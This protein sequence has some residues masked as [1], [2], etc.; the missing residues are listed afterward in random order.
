MKRT[1][2]SVVALFLCLA[3]LVLPVLTSCDRGGDSGGTN[4]ENTPE[5]S[6][7]VGNGGGSNSVPDSGSSTPDNGNSNPDT[8]PTTPENGNSGGSESSPVLATGVTLN[9]TTLSL[10]KGS[11]ETLTA[12]VAPDDTTDT[13]L[14]WSTSNENVATVNNNG[15]VTAVGAGTATITVTTANGKTATC[16]VTVSV[17]ASGVSLNKNNLSLIKGSSETL[18]ATVAPADTTDKTVNWTSSN[19]SVVTVANGT[20]TAVAAGMATITVTTANGK[21]ATCEVT[22]SVLA[23]GVSLNKN[24]LSLIKGSSETLT[25]T[26]APADTTDKTLTWTSSNTSVVTVVNGT[27][28]AVGAGTTTITVTTANG[29]TATCDVTV[30]VLASGVSLNKNTL[31]LIKGNSETLTA[32]VA[33]ADAINKNVSWTT[34]NQN[35]VTV[36]NGTVT[37]VGAGTATITVTDA[38]G[39]TDTCEV[40]VTVLALGITLD[41]SSI[42]LN[43]GETNTLVATIAPADTTDKSL[44]WESSNTI[45]A[46]VID[47][48]VTAVSAGTT[49]ITVTTANGKAATCQVTVIAN[50]I[51]FKTL[52]VTGTDIYGKVSN[53]TTTFSF[54]NEVGVSGNATFEVYRDLECSDIIRSK[55]TTL[56]IGDNTFYILEYISGEVNALYTVTVRRK[57]MYTV[58]F[59]TKGGMAVSNQSI[60]EDSFVTVPTTTR[61]GYTFV[62][63]DRDLALPITDNTSISAQWSNNPYTVTYNANGGE[64]TNSSTNVAYGLSYTLETPTRAGYTFA[65]WYY[66]ATPIS[67]TGTW[68][69]SES[70]MLKAEWTANTNTS[71]RVKHY[72]EKLDGSY[73]LKDT[74]NLTGT[75]DAEVTPNTKTYAGFTEPTTQTVTVLP[76]GTQA[77][78][79]YYTRNSYTI[80]FLNEDGTEIETK[81]LKYE[82]EY[83]FSE[84][85]KTG[86]AFGWY[87]GDEKFTQL[88]G[89][90]TITESK[91]LKATWTA[92]SNTAYKVEHYIEK[93]DGSY[94]LKDTD[95]LTGTS[96]T[97]IK[98]ET[99][100]Y[101]GFTAPVTQTVTVLPDGSQV[102]E[103]Y[104]TRNNYAVSFDSNG[105]NIVQPV[106][107]KYGE[108][109]RLPEPTRTGYTFIGW[110]DGDDAFEANGTWSIVENVA[111]KAEWTAN[112]DTTYKVEHYIEKLDGMYEIKDTDNLTG[113][114]DS[115]VTPVIKNY[116]GF[117]APVTQTVTVLP[118][119][120]QV[121]KY[122]YT[123]NSYT[124]SFDSNGG[125]TVQSVTI[126]Y[127][128]SYS[129]TESERTGYTFVGWYDGDDAFELNGTWSIVENVTLKAEWSLNS[130]SLT[131]TNE[132]SAYGSVT[133][134]GT[135][136]YNSSVTVTA[137][138]V[139][140]NTFLGW[141]DSNGNMLSSNECFTFIKKFDE[142]IEARWKFTVDMADFTFTFDETSCVITGVHDQTKTEY[143]I[144]DYVTGI[145]DFAFCDCKNI[146]SIA[147]PDSITNIG[148][149]SFR[150]CDGLNGVYIDSLESW[151]SI[152]F[153]HAEYNPLF[154]AGNLY[155]NGSLVTTLLIPDG[156]TYINT[157][158]FAY[159]DSIESVVISDTVKNISTY[160]FLNCMN[161][162][163]V[164]VGSAVEN[165][166]NSA[167][168]G[169]GRLVEIIN[170][171]NL[172]IV[173]GNL[174]EYGSIA[175]YAKEVH[176]GSSKI[177]SVDEFLFY[178][179]S[180]TTYLLGYHGEN[181][182]LILP[183]NYNGRNYILND[184]VFYRCE[185]FTNIAISNGVI[186]IGACAFWGCN[187]LEN[188]IIPD[189][190]VTIGESAFGNCRNLKS[191]TLSD[192]IIDIGAFAFDGCSKLE[193]VKI[194]DSVKNI[195]S[196]V[197]GVCD[198]L[199]YTE[200]NNGKYL[201]DDKNPYVVLIDVI[202]KDVVNYTIP[203]ETNIIYQN[204][205]ENCAK[206][207]TIIIPSGIT[208]IGD[209][210]FYNCSSLV[211]LIFA[212]DSQ[213]SSIGA[214]SFLNCKSISSV[215]IPNSVTS[216][217]NGAFRDCVSVKSISIP[218]SLKNVSNNLFYGCTKVE[219]LTISNGVLNIGNYAFYGCEELTNIIIPNS[220]ERIGFSAFYGCN[221]LE[222]ITLP[223]IGETNGET[224]NTHLGYIF[225]GSY[226]ESGNYGY[227]PETLTSVTVTAAKEIGDYAFK[228]CKSIVSITISEG[229]SKIGYEAFGYC[230]RLTN[231][232]IP[233]SVTIISE[234]AFRRCIG[235][236]S[237][238]IP[239]NVT[240]IGNNVFY[241]CTELAS[242]VFFK[243][244]T[245]IGDNAFYNCTKLSSIEFEDDSQ[246]MRIGSNA[247]YNTAYYNSQSNWE[248]NV[249]YIGTFLIEAQRTISGIY[250]IKDGTTVIGS[251]AFA[252]CYNLQGVIMPK[253]VM[254]INQY[255]FKDASKCSTYYEGSPAEWSEITFGAFWSPNAPQIYDPNYYS[256]N[257]P[258]NDN[259]SYWRYVGGVPTRW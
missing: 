238:V 178:E 215:E 18:T 141:Y 209:Y 217:G 98:P 180:E 48:T 228:G 220:V 222:H 62:G 79:Y 216:V 6:T 63:W 175:T 168:W 219:T 49:T 74:D 158:A 245:H 156:V 11:S 13:T 65:G 101:I 43:A 165:I 2:K 94:E 91:T 108:S 225:G 146:T 61:T 34:S 172:N 207:T 176:S 105:G 113:T 205:F 14:T 160:A 174:Y 199:I 85:S 16:E 92:N 121:V 149:S 255:A 224:Q 133:G 161:I 221:K 5:Q 72:I 200:Y 64:V 249:L 257:R 129:L 17:L 78:K 87:D 235:I 248:D 4:L 76:D 100:T 112:T 147:L 22:V 83:S 31:S 204:A 38:N 46:T 102:V 25:A 148:E 53:T 252:Y 104:Y 246:L 130:Y 196:N 115:E 127:G 55:T 39:N 186:S 191:I 54:I 30:S 10:V 167:F 134:G 193:T 185:Q 1:C 23:S 89:I 33:P 162:R 151:C 258:I 71:Y 144:P 195:G 163:S 239:E 132:N 237:I 139:L 243:K 21:T 213:L 157:S 116:T 81:T 218:G 99:K 177:V 20:V 56:N 251:Y 58:T 234:N 26:V 12:T 140:N 68:N 82:Q 124:V 45:V 50:G 126:K 51:S 125:T 44:T 35:I 171:S 69:I 253:S 256:Q 154:Y 24:N 242:I 206:L 142:S 190:V 153:T 95:N 66:G 77:V 52:G 188:I 73:E 227:V 15:V 198:A 114:S 36:V 192:G 128:Q 236:T 182:N 7:P 230:N 109:Y 57:P 32:T 117:T 259:Y 88:S 110:Y 229:V 233:K 97:N 152:P 19:T 226:V 106:T 232:T 120:S 137:T 194:P 169:C 155:L 197:F 212:G 244:V 107:I 181:T 131:I 3:M 9:K 122:Y 27:V 159:C 170:H 41:K 67:I 166:D 123:R 164:T 145:G 75:S 29:K 28:T 80:T 240:Y 241:D 119:G 214:Y 210:A 93:L 136:H 47:G 247:F 70:I 201:G 96:D 59:D 84:Q 86:Y 203:S 179:G 118:N 211:D 138:P 40:T 223:F 42:Q 37:A 90:W 208:S 183:L 202:D 187:G 60:E 143:V 103:Y 254:S 173:A 231:V 189:S 150:G 184:Y 8:D 135:Y 250:T 111:L